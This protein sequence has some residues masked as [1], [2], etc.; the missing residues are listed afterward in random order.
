MLISPFY[1][2]QDLLRHGDS[3]LSPDANKS[4][5]NFAIIIY[6]T[7][8]VDSA[9]ASAIAWLA[10]E[11]YTQSIY[12]PYV[13]ALVTLACM[14]YVFVVTDK[15]IVT[16]DLFSEEKLRKDEYKEIHP[17][18]NALLN[19]SLNTLLYIGYLT[20][21]PFK[22]MFSAKPAAAMM[23]GS[24]V[25]FMA[26]IH[27]AAILFVFLI[28]S[29]APR[30]EIKANNRNIIQNINA[31]IASKKKSLEENDYMVKQLKDD[32]AR[33][34]KNMSF[35]AEE[36]KKTGPGTKYRYYKEE[37][38]KAERALENRLKEVI[39]N[40]NLPDPV[41]LNK[42]NPADP[43]S[44][45]PSAFIGF[46][47]TGNTLTKDTIDGRASY[48]Y[49]KISHDPMAFLTQIMPTIGMSILLITPLFVLVL[50]KVFQNR[51]V[52]HY[53]D[54]ELQEHYQYY[55]NGL[56][57]W[58]LAEKM[59]S[60]P[61]QPGAINP[62]LFS[63]I[64]YGVIKKFF[65][66]MQNGE[67][68][69]L[70]SR[71]FKL[72]ENLLELDKEIETCQKQIDT[73]NAEADRVRGQ[74]KVLM[75]NIILVSKEQKNVDAVKSFNENVSHLDISLAEILAELKTQQSLKAEIQFS[76]KKLEKEIDKTQQRITHWYKEEGSS[77]EIRVVLAK[78]LASL[79]PFLSDRVLT[80]IKEN[81][82]A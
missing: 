63:D 20:A 1:V 68:L 65:Q 81:T 48:I 37:K 32:I 50:M 13:S 10:A 52:R 56:Y 39:K 46:S 4:L 59:L 42:I 34:A 64:Y 30:E 41:D 54:I 28:I 26:S 53:Y 79:V 75:E 44:M 66:C 57:N 49:N 51:S 69:I 22:V 24:R 80:H 78:N 17:F 14:A 43:A 58:L 29:P 15:S 73:L 9:Y 72:E 74:R 6:V 76:K 36:S 55:L 47:A 2:T 11:H 38:E 77:S 16:S 23:L 21:A 3:L 27:V 33:F 35:E 67:V 7:V 62:I 71:F 31:E 19:K 5:R 12:I 70:E 60:T 40:A 8:F 25:I 18:K 82:V 61:N 45:L